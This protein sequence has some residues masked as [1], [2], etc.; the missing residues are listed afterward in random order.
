MRR[1]AS[2]WWAAAP[3]AGDVVDRRLSAAEA[4]LDAQDEFAHVVVNDRL[5]DAL[6][7]LREIVLASIE[8]R[9][10]WIS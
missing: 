10:D 2:A 1:C 8:R 3:T 6:R 4:E 9:V 5:E 7:E